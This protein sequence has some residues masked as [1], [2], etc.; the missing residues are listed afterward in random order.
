MNQDDICSAITSLAP[1][2][3]IQD[4]LDNREDTVER[5]SIKSRLGPKTADLEYTNKHYFDKE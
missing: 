5:N 3:E 1:V 2:K 4:R